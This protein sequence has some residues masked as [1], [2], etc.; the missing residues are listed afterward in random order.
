MIWWILAYYTAYVFFAALVARAALDIVLWA[1][2]E[3]ELT[4]LAEQERHDRA[5]ARVPAIVAAYEDRE[6]ELAVVAELR[7]TA[8]EHYGEEG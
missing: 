5:E 3:L 7:R 8:R 4:R 1:D 6:R 2:Q